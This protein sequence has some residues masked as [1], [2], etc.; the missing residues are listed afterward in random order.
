MTLTLV[1]KKMSYDKEYTCETESYIT[2]H[3][4]VMANVKAIC[5]QTETDKQTD[6]QTDWT[7]PIYP[8][9]IDAGGGGGFREASKE[10]Y[11]H[12]RN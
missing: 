1:P 6:K 3:S 7:K 4:K 8:Q 5:R 10:L 2:Y 12:F 9:S 11:K